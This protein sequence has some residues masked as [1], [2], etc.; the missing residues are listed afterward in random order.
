M[1][2]STL[3]KA[4]A[5]LFFKTL[6]DLETSEYWKDVFLKCCDGK[7]PLRCNLSRD[8]KVM[9]LT[10]AKG[11]NNVSGKVLLQGEPETMLETIKGIFKNHC[12]LSSPEDVKVNK[13]MLT[14]SKNTA[15]GGWKESWKNM[16][17][18]KSMMQ[19]EL[20]SYIDRF[21]EKNSLD[22]NEKYEMYNTLLTGILLN[23]I[24]DDNVVFREGM[25]LKIRNLK[26]DKIN[27][28]SSIE[29]TTKK[30]EVIAKEAGKKKLSDY[31]QQ[32]T[33]RRKK[34]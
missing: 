23:Q 18:N 15:E 4:N 17:K 8:G 20:V 19:V 27:R 5:L 31:L 26:W 13:K 10:N 33:K 1:P 29:Y 22:E 21:S 11:F 3:K 28:R 12:K 30:K 14:S 24:E 25:I 6:H 32:T 7:L 34:N 2:P 16:K 9:Y